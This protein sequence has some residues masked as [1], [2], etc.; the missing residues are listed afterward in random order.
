MPRE[1]AQLADTYDPDEVIV[2]GPDAISAF[3]SMGR[4]PYPFQAEDVLLIHKYRGGIEGFWYRL[5]DGRVFDKHGRP[6]E[7]ADPAYFRARLH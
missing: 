2:Y 6:S 1:Y 4:R 7:P 5:H 3:M